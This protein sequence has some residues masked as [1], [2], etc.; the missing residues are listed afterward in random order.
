MDRRQDAARGAAR[1]IA[2]EDVAFRHAAAEFVDQLARGD[3]GRRQL[4]AGILDPARDRE[5]A[6]PLAPAAALAGEPFRALLDDVAHPIQRL[7][8]VDERRAAEQPDLRR[9]RA[10]CGAAARAC[11]RCFPASPIPRRRYR[12]RRRAA[13]ESGGLLREARFGFKSARSRVPADLAALRIFV[14]QIDIDRRAPPPPRRRSACLR[15]C[16]ADR[17]RD[18]TRSL[19]VPGSP[20]SALIAISRGAFRRVAHQ[21]PFAAG[22]EAGAAQAAQLPNP[23]AASRS[24]RACSRPS[25]QDCAASLIAAARRDNRRSRELGA[26]DLARMGLD[27]RRRAPD[28]GDAVEARMLVQRMAD[29]PP[30]ARCGSRPCR[31]RARRARRRPELAGQLRQQ[32][33][34]P[35]SA[36]VRLSQT[37]TV[38][39][40]GAGSPSMTMSK[41]A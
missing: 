25:R 19:K 18:N 37:R 6:R 36:Q 38:S 31:A 30:P 15:A 5:A 2:L 4:D 35:N 14:A 23:P 28:R 16:G 17:F 7:D 39:G 10:A 21:A 22:R 34:A 40:G 9:D 12:R 41:W 1:Q 11:P 13:G 3:A 29:A 8:I 27:A 33:S 20:S 24:P 26:A 32:R